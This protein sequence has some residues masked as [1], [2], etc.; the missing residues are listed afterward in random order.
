MHAALRAEVRRW[1]LMPVNQ[2]QQRAIAFLAAAAR[3]YGA[4]A[5]DESGILANVAKVADR[6]LASVVIAVMRAAEDRNATTPGVIPTNGP[7]WRDPGS[8]PPPPF[9]PFDQ[10]AFCGTCGKPEARC[11]STRVADDDHPFESVLSMRRRREA[12]NRDIPR[13]VDHLRDE[14]VTAKAAPVV[15]AE[16]PAPPPN[17][18]AEAARKA[19]AKESA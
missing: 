7:H 3:P 9:E 11:Q 18:H 1:V 6:N 15:A 12:D 10:S 17:E 2:Q 14:L 19:L 13:V 5:W 8:A 16:K 4:P